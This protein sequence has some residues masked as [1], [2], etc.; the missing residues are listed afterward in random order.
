MRELTRLWLMLA[1]A[2]PCALGSS[3]AAWADEHGTRIAIIEMG[4]IL[5]QATAVHSIRS[6]GEAQRRIYA[7]EAQRDSERLRV[8]R[9][10]LIQQQTLLAPAALEERQ[11]AFNAEVAA[12]E[13]RAKAHNQL[14]QRAVAQGEV[15]FREI[16]GV[17]VAQI[18]ETRGI[19]IVLPVHAALF[20]IPEVNLT[21]PVIQRL[22]EV[23]PEIALTFDES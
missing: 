16:L 8:F 19:E 3:A 22:N 23:F 15:R 20:A 1:L 9:D 5:E 18:A 17:V 2:V 11:R 12:A 10:E 7:E 21:E 14:L 4:R 13:Q 6:Q